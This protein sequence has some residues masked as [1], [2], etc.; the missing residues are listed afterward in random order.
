MNKNQPTSKDFNI[1]D[2][3]QGRTTTIEIVKISPDLEMFKDNTGIIYDS[4]T[5]HFFVPKGANVR[6]ALRDAMGVLK[7]QKDKIYAVLKYKEFEV[8]FGRDE[9]FADILGYIY[10]VE[11][12]MKSQ[13]S[14]NPNF[15][16]LS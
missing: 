4:N 15:S 7:T 10:A 12:F 3:N 14:T 6:H 5:L 2:A 16:P 8:S 13:F 11:D 9:K 1:E